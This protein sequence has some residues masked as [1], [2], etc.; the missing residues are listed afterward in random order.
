[1]QR[2]KALVLHGHEKLDEAGLADTTYLSLLTDGVIQAVTISPDMLGLTPAPTSELRGGEVKDNAD[3]LS[4]VLQ[5]RGTQAQQDIVALNAALALDA[6]DK[7]TS[8]SSLVET[9]QS[10]IELARDILK[11]GAAWQKFETLAD[12]LK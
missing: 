7:L 1:M 5:G 8:K 4:A 6:G 11:S 10:G 3:I 12:F 2:P 9:Y